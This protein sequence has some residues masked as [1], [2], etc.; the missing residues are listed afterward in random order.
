MGEVSALEEPRALV[1]PQMAIDTTDKGESKPELISPSA[2]VA[3]ERIYD[4]NGF[5]TK[6][7]PPLGT[8]VASERKV[9]ALEVLETLIDTSGP[10]DARFEPRSPIALVASEHAF[11]IGAVLETAI[12]TSG[13][14]D[15]R[16]EPQ[17]PIALV[18][19]ENAFDIGA[20][21][22]QE[23]ISPEG[24]VASEHTFDVN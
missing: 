20:L 16:F 10:E 2:V 24:P 17:S 12:D 19:S 23:T 13:P 22:D 18:A 21:C 6:S 1:M 8:L 4:L 11:D 14:E 15:A 9:G 3:S 7:S 5:C